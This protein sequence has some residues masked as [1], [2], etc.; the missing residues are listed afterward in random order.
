MEKSGRITL[1]SVLTKKVNSAIKCDCFSSLQEFS[2]HQ[3]NRE[4][5]LREH[6]RDTRRV[7]QGWRD[8]GANQ[9]IPARPGPALSN[10]LSGHAAIVQRRYT[11]GQSP[12]PQTQNPVGALTSPCQSGA[13]LMRVVFV[14]RHQFGCVTRCH[15]SAG[16]LWVESVPAKIHHTTHPIEPKPRSETGTRSR[17]QPIEPHRTDFSKKGFRNQRFTAETFWPLKPG[18]E[19]A[20]QNKLTFYAIGLISWSVLW[21]ALV[22]S[23]GDFIRYVRRVARASVAHNVYA[24]NAR[25]CGTVSHHFEQLPMMIEAI[26]RVTH[27]S[28]S[29]IKELCA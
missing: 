10:Q 12:L 26:S 13:E 23:A 14:L 15:S 21:F 27:I 22:C 7:R 16:Q 11:E 28:I 18:H 24:L 9:L 17:Q 20:T 8:G 6:W 3:L 4:Q 5:R 25:I 1:Y 2:F 19:C 29:N